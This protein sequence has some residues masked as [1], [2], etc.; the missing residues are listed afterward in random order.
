M[1]TLF[2]TGHRW[3]LIASSRYTLS[4]MPGLLDKPEGRLREGRITKLVEGPQ[5]NSPHLQRMLLYDPVARPVE[6]AA[7]QPELILF[8]AAKL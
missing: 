4:P 6:T 5:T 1:L 2:R 7:V 3:E 8:Q